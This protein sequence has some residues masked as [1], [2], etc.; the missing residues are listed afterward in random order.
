MR[1]GAGARVHGPTLYHVI[2]VLFSLSQHTSS[3]RT[4]ADPRPTFPSHWRPSIFSHS[5]LFHC[6]A[7][8]KRSRLYRCLLTP[9]LPATMPSL[10]H[11][12]RPPATS[13]APCPPFYLLG[14]PS[15]N[16]AYDCPSTAGPTG[17][18]LSTRCSV[19]TP[20]I[21]QT[22]CTSVPHAS[23]RALNYIRFTNRE[24][25]P[26]DLNRSGTRIIAQ[27]QICPRRAS[28]AQS[29]S[30]LL[31]SFPNARRPCAEISACIIP[32]HQRA[33]R[34]SAAFRRA[35]CPRVLPQYNAF[36][37]RPAFM[38]GAI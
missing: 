35:A 13:H 9:S 1:G 15:H 8:Q 2:S 3:G 10:C 11:N 17:P 24:P 31:L 30:S 37:A 7:L 34:S 18:H 21:R 33:P 6:R 19:P 25:T 26:D 29:A 38:C 23:S 32:L 27:T 28:S 20:S 4:H 12:I 5:A 16:N 36:D 14:P 22:G